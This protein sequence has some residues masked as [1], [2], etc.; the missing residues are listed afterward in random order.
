MILL[1]LL[2]KLYGKFIV[3]KLLR[4]EELSKFLCGI[5]T[6]NSLHGRRNAIRPITVG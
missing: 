3:L 4:A 2:L 5:S 1:L 6:S